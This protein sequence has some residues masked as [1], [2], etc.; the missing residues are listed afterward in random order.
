MAEKNKYTA[1]DTAFI[2]KQNYKASYSYVL[3]L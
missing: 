1:D 3:Y 2:K